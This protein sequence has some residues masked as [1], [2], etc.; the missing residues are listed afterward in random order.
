MH[1]ILIT[2][3]IGP[4]GL[5]LLDAAAD[6]TYDVVKLPAPDQLIER[7][8]DDEGLITRSGTPLTARASA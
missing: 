8:G 5:A 4:A 7:I 2:D 1:N 6:V 3:D